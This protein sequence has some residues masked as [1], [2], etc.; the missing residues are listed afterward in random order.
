MELCKRCMFDVLCVSFTDISAA[1]LAP[2]V[3]QVAVALILA[4]QALG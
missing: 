3:V 4:E 2:K 1:F